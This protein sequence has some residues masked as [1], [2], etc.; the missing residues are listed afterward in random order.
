YI[1]ATDG[2]HSAL[3]YP[4]RYRDGM[5]NRKELF[6][7]V[8]ALKSLDQEEYNDLEAAAG[9][10]KMAYPCYHDKNPGRDLPG[11]N[12]AR[13]VIESDDVDHITTVED[14]PEL[15]MMSFLEDAAPAIH[16]KVVTTLNNPH[17]GNGT[18]KH[19]ALLPP[20][21]YHAA[22]PSSSRA[23]LEHVCTKHV[24]DLNSRRSPVLVLKSTGKDLQGEQ[25][26]PKEKNAARQTTRVDVDD[27]A[28]F[29]DDEDDAEGEV[30]DASTGTSTSRKVHREKSENTPQPLQTSTAE[31]VCHSSSTSTTKSS[32]QRSSFPPIVSYHFRTA[33]VY[34]FKW[35]RGMVPKM[36]RRLWNKLRQMPQHDWSKVVE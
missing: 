7:G 8:F 9:S 22:T 5:C 34:H 35:V 10:G 27:E 14:D 11:K 21:H 33:T 13:Q 23:L 15:L 36:E 18:M 30:T 1:R 20:L 29:L 2:T 4:R 26:G 32:Q 12:R 28:A 24:G 3:G 16:E 31:E 25:D 19:F 17:M 6:D